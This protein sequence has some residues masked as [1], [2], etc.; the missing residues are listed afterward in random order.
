MRAA[1]C[2]S[3]LW[4]VGELFPTRG[5]AHARP[6]AASLLAP[7]PGL[8]DSTWKSSLQKQP[9]HPAPLPLHSPR[10][11]PPQHRKTHYPPPPRTPLPFHSSPPTL[12]VWHSDHAHAGGF[13][14]FRNEPRPDA[15][16]AAVYCFAGRQP[17]AAVEGF[18]NE[19]RTSVCACV[20]VC[21]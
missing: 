18:P 3:G 12:L 21:F 5:G 11:H 10:T 1:W 17:C 8:I 4:L 9:L 15:Q 16:P 13:P 20:C 14:T 6:V 7:F 19:L 2:A